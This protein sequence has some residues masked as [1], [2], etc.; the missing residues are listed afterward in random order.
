MSWELLDALG[1]YL[2]FASQS[3]GEA[4]QFIAQLVDAVT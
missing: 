4:K 1:L 3:S 2:S